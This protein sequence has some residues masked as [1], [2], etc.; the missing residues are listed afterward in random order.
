MSIELDVFS[1]NSLRSNGAVYKAHK[2]K[3]HGTHNHGPMSTTCDPYK[4]KRYMH[5]LHY[6]MKV[7]KVGIHHYVV[8]NLMWQICIH[9]FGK[10]RKYLVSFVHRLL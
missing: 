4:S 10:F 9:T 2:G 7:N 5:V 6:K 1:P 8:S 3:W